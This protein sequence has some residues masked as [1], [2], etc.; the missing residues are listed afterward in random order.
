MLY[1]CNLSL[2]SVTYSND[3]LSDTVEV[4]I[5]NALIG[6][7]LTFAKSNGGDEWNNFQTETLFDQ[8]QL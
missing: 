2:R 3:G 7:F 4:L 8:K 6:Y 1:T 5:N